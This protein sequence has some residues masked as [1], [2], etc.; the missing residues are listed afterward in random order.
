LHETQV[1]GNKLNAFKNELVKMS[2]VVKVS[3][4]GFLPAGISR[5]SVDG[6]QVINGERIV[7]HRTKSYYIDE[8]YL[9]TLGMKIAQGRNFSKAFP[10][11]NMAILI[12]EAAAKAYGFKNPIGEQ[13]SLTGDGSNGS[14]K[15]YT[16]V[17]VIK[18]FHFESMHQNIAPLIMFYGGDNAQ[19][20]LR[21]KTDDIPTILYNI[22]KLWKAQTDNPFMYSFLDERFNSMYQAEQRIGQLFGIFAGLAIFISCLGLF[23]LAAFATHQRTKEIGVRKVLGASIG[24]I[25]SLLLSN[26]LKLILIAILIASPIAGYVMSH[27]L[28]EFAYRIDLSWWIFA[29]AGVMAISIAVLTVS[30]QTLKAALVN[31]VKSLKVE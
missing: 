2:T 17:G 9:P 4:A 12:N 30:Y 25:V 20:A 23:G 19:L 5:K 26:F 10:T 13:V 31:P 29:L 11:D 27:W 16:I 28:H 1:L 24:S 8:D 22:E 7:N 3:L 18:D 14:K 15:T 6:V 21:I